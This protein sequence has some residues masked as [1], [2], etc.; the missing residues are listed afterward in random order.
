MQHTYLEINFY[1]AGIDCR[2]LDA[3]RSNEGKDYIENDL[4]NI[5]KKIYKD[6]DIYVEDQFLD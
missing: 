5:G 3:D 2:F 6:V 4:K 1:K